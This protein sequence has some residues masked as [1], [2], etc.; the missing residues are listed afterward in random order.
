MIIALG[1]CCCNS[2]LVAT[3]VNP[4]LTTVVLTDMTGQEVSSYFFKSQY[5]SFWKIDHCPVRGRHV[6]SQEKR[7]SCH[8][9]VIQ[10]ISRFLQYPGKKQNSSLTHNF[11]ILYPHIFHQD[12]HQRVKL[13]DFSFYFFCPPSGKSSISS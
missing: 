4:L 1:L 12:H 5:A 7:S 3:C 6:F 11:N 10:T 9:Q 13:T 2:H 8:H